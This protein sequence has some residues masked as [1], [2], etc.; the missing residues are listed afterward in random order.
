VLGHE[1]A[2]ELG[3]V[4]LDRELV[5]LLQIA[6]PDD[7]GR[8]AGEPDEIGLVS[9]D[10]DVVELLVREERARRAE[11]VAVPAASLA[12]E[13]LP[14]ALGRR[15]DRVRVARDEAVERRIAREL[16]PLERRDGG[17][18]ILERA[19]TTEGLRNAVAYSG[20]ARTFRMTSSPFFCPISM[21]FVI[22]SFACSSSVAARPS[23]NWVALKS[24]FVTVGLFRCVRCF[25]AATPSASGLWSTNPLAG[26]WQVAQETLS[27]VE[28]RTSL[29]SFSP[30]ASFAGVISD[31]DGTDRSQSTRDTPSGNASGFGTAG[32]AASAGVT[33]ASTTIAGTVSLPRRSVIPPPVD[34]ISSRSSAGSLIVGY[35]TF[36]VPAI[37]ARGETTRFGAQRSLLAGG[38][39]SSACSHSAS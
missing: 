36:T 14:A 9:G 13:E 5:D 29:K 1:E 19:L 22:G 4:G 25:G 30:S 31:A 17:G 20:M 37:P 34:G 38:F 27:L 23:Q 16:R 3:K 21:G 28:S 24:A 8:L 10:A 35:G 2:P 32:G 18:E 26:S 6:A 15:T 7:A 39:P 33:R 11:G 12:V